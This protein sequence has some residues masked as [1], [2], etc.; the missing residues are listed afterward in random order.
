MGR[1]GYFLS[2]VLAVHWL[3]WAWSRL[4]MSWAGHVLGCAL[5]WLGWHGLN[6]DWALHGLDSLGMGWAGHGLDLGISCT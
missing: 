5:A 6:I 1:C 4:G 3:G 2:M